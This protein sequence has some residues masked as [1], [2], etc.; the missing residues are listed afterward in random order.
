MNPKVSVIIP[1]YNLADLLPRTI[2]SVLNQTFKDFVHGDQSI[3]DNIV[4][5]R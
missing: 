2:K 1:T 5:K 3:F 4:F